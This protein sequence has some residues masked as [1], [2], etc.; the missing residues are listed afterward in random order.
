MLLVVFASLPLVYVDIS[1][2]SRGFIRTPNENTTI[3]SAVYGQVIANNMYENK[4]VL[5]GDTLL[6]L[7]ADR[8]MEQVK[9]N[10]IKIEQSDEFIADLEKL[11]SGKYNEFITAKYL[12]EYNR[13]R[14]KLSELNTN[15]AYFE[16]EYKI[17]S[18]L[19]EQNVISKHEYLRTKNNFENVKEQLN[20]LTKEYRLHGNRKKR[21]LNFK[22]RN[23]I[24]K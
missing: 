1:S 10:T 19:C 23:C 12:G 18:V 7:N 24:R 15:F 11:S 13:Y 3:Q 4:S 22:M 21:I 9:L 20:S 17:D 6:V 5:V 16:N 14:A 8:F 2:Q